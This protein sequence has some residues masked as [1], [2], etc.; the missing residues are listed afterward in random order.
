VSDVVMVRGATNGDRVM[1][2]HGMV[3]PDKLGHLDIPLTTLQKR[4]ARERA[5]SRGQRPE[6]AVTGRAGAARLR[7]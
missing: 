1:A 2:V 3:N 5:S 6:I 4:P 7:P